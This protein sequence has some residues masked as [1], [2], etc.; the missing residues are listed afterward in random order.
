M[1][2]SGGRRK[3]FLAQSIF[4]ASAFLAAASVAP[5]A[6]AQAPTTG[7][8]AGYSSNAGKPI[9]IEADLLEVDDKKKIAVFKG[10]V[11]ATQGD[12][13]IRASEILVTY[14]DSNK[15]AGTDKKPPPVKEVAASPLPGGNGSIKQIDAKGKVL[16]TGKDNQTAT[17]DWAIFEVEKQLV[18][19]GGDVVVS[20]GTDTIKANRLV[21]DVA[22]GLTRV[23]QV[24]DKNEGEKSKRIQMIITPKSR[25]KQEKPDKPEKHEKPQ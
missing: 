24:A 5:A 20:R 2:S 19:L 21:I 25:E 18:T 16:V 17:S 8:A 4:C 22:T 14:T 3:A 6:F 15:T 10:N 1:N 13:N 7:L 9:D 11:S 12:F 23:E